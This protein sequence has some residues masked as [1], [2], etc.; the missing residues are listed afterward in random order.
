MNIHHGIYPSFNF[1]ELDILRIFDCCINMVF[2]CIFIDRGGSSVKS[3]RIQK[4]DA[5]GVCEWRSH[6]PVGGSGGMLPQKILKTRAPQMLFP[7]FWHVNFKQKSNAKMSK[8]I[9]KLVIYSHYFLMLGIK[10]HMQLIYSACQT[11]CAW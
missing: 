2:L 11:L 9:A 7:A 8:K 5:E 3:D 6:E 4:L 10:F 1:L